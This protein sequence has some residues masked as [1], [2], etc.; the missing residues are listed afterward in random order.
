VCVYVYVAVFMES[1]LPDDI[2]TALRYAPMP[3]PPYLCA[4]ALCAHVLMCLQTFLLVFTGVN[5]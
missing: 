5:L 3:L 4:L 1:A 2:L